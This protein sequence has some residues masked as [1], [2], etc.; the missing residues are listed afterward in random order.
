MNPLRDS[1]DEDASKSSSSGES[2]PEENQ[3]VKPLLNDPNLAGLTETK[4]KDKYYQQPTDNNNDRKSPN[5]KNGRAMVFIN[6][7]D[8]SNNNSR[9]LHLT[10]AEFYQNENWLVDV[11]EILFKIKERNTTIE[12]ELYYGF[13]HFISC[14]FVLAVIPQLLA[15]A[16]Y[17]A[18]TTVVAVGAC[19]G[20]G[21]IIGGLF[22]N[23]PFII[24]P[25]SVVSIFLAVFLQSQNMGPTEGSAAVVISGFPLLLLFWRPLAL[26]I[27]KLIPLPIRIGTTLGVGLVTALAGA[28]EVGLIED[29]AYS[30]LQLGEMT[31]AIYIGAIG[32]I[33][34]SIGI[35][36]H[37]KG[38]FVIAMIG[39]SFAWWI[40]TEEWPKKAVAV[41]N[42]EHID[43]TGFNNPKIY[44]LAFELFF[45]YVLYFGGLIPSLTDQA[46]LRREDGTT[47]RGRWF[48]VIGGVMTILSGSILS[49]PILISPESSAGIKAGAKTGLSTMVCGVLF[50]ISIFFAPLFQAVPT[51]AT[52]PVLMMIGILLFQDVNRIDWKDIE[53][54]APAFVTM[55]FIPMTYSIIY[56]I[57]MGYIVYIIMGLFTGSA[58]KRGAEFLQ[59]YFPSFTS[60]KYF[61]PHPT[62]ISTKNRRLSV[63]RSVDAQKL[64]IDFNEDVEASEDFPIFSSTRVRGLSV[65]TYDREAV[66]DL[67]VVH[68][69]YDFDMN[70]SILR[71]SNGYSVGNPI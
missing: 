63:R 58:F 28:V 37:I 6:D 71:S 34:I 49:A 8:H 23:L 43:N 66:R 17:S 53:D 7:T 16:N 38:A 67:D 30:L 36:Y 20:I 65:Y 55:F 29:G 1:K 52:S 21:S 10:K 60:L 69:E 19:C 4:D 24:A 48:Y 18:D 47:P 41:P 70:E 61:N 33:G 57:T 12:N 51:A 39:C 13:V 2:T 26:L 3:L 42:I 45:L 50:V 27:G 54:S 62:I 40:I 44:Q 59:Y 11:C 15:N 5:P 14:F 31:L 56:G 22:T 9:L 64:G 35:V 32:M 46:N 68:E 25:I